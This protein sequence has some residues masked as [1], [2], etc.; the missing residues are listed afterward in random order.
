MQFLSIFAILFC[1]QPENLFETPP[2]VSNSVMYVVAVAYTR[3][4][5]ASF[6]Q[7]LDDLADR[8]ADMVQPSQLIL[9]VIHSSEE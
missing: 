9:E 5:Q 7:R 1:W 6:E 4:I 3:L 8:V 2:V